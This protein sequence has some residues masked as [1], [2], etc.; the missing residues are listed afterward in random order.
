MPGHFDGLVG[1]PAKSRNGSHA[2]LFPPQ[3]LRLPRI[4]IC[5][6]QAPY[7]PEQLCAL[8]AR[9]RMTRNLHANYDLVTI[10]LDRSRSLLNANR[11]LASDV[12]GD[13]LALP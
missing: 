3:P 1:G 2:A 7:M 5:F 11:D 6:W 10:A 4:C 8:N 13:W 9:L 12:S